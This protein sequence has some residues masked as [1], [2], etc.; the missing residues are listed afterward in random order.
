MSPKEEQ[1]APDDEQRPPW[2]LPEQ[3]SEEVP[4]PFPTVVEVPIRSEGSAI[5]GALAAVDK[6][7]KLQVLY[8]ELSSDD[9]ASL[10][11][12]N[13]RF[14]VVNPGRLAAMGLVRGDLVTGMGGQNLGSRA[15][16]A[17]TLARGDTPAL[18][19]DRGGARFL[20]GQTLV[21]KAR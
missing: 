7:R 13:A 1:A 4:Q 21:A 17:R 9:L 2:Q 16:F 15:A 3:Q 14:M 19:I 11:S 12:S 8:P 18:S 20:I 10:A 6:L 5:D